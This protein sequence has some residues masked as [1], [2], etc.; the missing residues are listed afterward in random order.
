LLNAQP[1][2]LIAP[3]SPVEL[4]AGVSILPNAGFPAGCVETVSSWK[5]RFPWPSER[6]KVLGKLIESFPPQG[7]VDGKAFEEMTD[8]KLDAM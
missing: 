6:V 1:V 2:T 4:F 5:S 8:W 3:E 7:K